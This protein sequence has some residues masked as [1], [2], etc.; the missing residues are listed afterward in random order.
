MW[1][2]DALTG[3][4]D[5]SSSSARG[6][7]GGWDVT[8]HETG[9]PRAWLRQSRIGSRTGYDDASEVIVLEGLGERRLDGKARE[10]RYVAAVKYRSLIK[11]LEGRGAEER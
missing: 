9:W 2:A 10:E 6:I 11:Q 3:L 4:E 7:V 8:T 5:D 1:R